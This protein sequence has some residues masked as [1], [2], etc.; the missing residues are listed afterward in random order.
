MNSYANSRTIDETSV[1]GCLDLGA[2]NA[3]HATNA[4]LK[5]GLKTCSITRDLKWGV[6][7]PHEK[8]KDEGISPSRHSTGLGGRSGGRTQR[9]LNSMSSWRKTMS[10]STWSCSPLHY[11]ELAKTGLSW[12]Q[13]VWLNILTTNQENSPKQRALQWRKSHE[14]S[15]WNLSILLAD[16]SSWGPVDQGDYDYYEDQDAEGQG[17]HEE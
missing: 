8:Y 16:E 1:A 13:L 12:R 9:M 17:E 6:P 3:I 14:Y 2:Q 15:Y 7:V 4:W 5:E 10:H 11:L